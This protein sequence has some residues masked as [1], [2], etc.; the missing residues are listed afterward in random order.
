LG[1]T[2]ISVIESKTNVKTIQCRKIARKTKIITMITIGIIIMTI[3][4]IITIL[5]ITIILITITLI[6]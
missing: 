4:G 2:N 5:I 1:I 3:I 6:I